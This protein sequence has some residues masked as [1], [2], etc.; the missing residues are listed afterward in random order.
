MAQTQV[1]ELLCYLSGRRPNNPSERFFINFQ[2]MGFTFNDPGTGKA[3]E[4]KLNPSN[5]IAAEPKLPGVAAAVDEIGSLATAKVPTRPKLDP[6]KSNA[7]VVL[8]TDMIDATSKLNPN[9]MTEQVVGGAKFTQEKHVN[10]KDGKTYTYTKITENGQEKYADYALRIVG[11]KLIDHK[12]E[13][14]ARV[15]VDYYQKQPDGSL[16]KDNFTGAQILAKSKFIGDQPDGSKFAVRMTDDYTDRAAKTDSNGYYDPAT[17]TLTLKNGKKIENVVIEV[18]LRPGE[19]VDRR[20]DD[21]LATVTKRGEEYLDLDAD[22]S[23]KKPYTVT[24]DDGA[25]Y[26]VTPSTGT[27]PKNA[28][29]D[30]PYAARMKV[31][32]PEGYREY[33]LKEKFILLTLNESEGA[34][35]KAIIDRELEGRANSAYTIVSYEG[36]KRVDTAV[37]FEKPIKVSVY[38][39][40]K[41]SEWKNV[42]DLDIKTT[43]GRSSVQNDLY[44][45][46]AAYDAELRASLKL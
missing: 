42:S 6:S 29:G 37:S 8:A 10:T 28:E 34:G 26:T 45:K 18:G 23:P 36:G 32:N 24:M 7:D 14:V 27:T 31:T 13:V 11:D 22:N 17:R 9:R 25:K 33:K 39:D 46:L 15:S 30:Y 19:S 16:V 20:Y 21:K 5:S 43:D 40:G 38:R 3:P 1:T 35:R 44:K 2:I 12:G 41:W 4:L